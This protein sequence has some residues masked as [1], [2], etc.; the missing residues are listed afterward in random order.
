MSK[1]YN[2]TYDEYIKAQKDL[3]DFKYGRIVYGRK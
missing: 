3:T 1:I 2:Y